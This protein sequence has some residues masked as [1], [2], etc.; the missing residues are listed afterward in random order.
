[1]LLLHVLHVRKKKQQRKN[2]LTIMKH[3]HNIKFSQ[4]FQ[5]GKIWCQGY[6]V[7]IYLIFTIKEKFDKFFKFVKYLKHN[8]CEMSPSKTTK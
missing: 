7:I 3:V 8:F 6:N 5:I 4:L 2:P 1:M